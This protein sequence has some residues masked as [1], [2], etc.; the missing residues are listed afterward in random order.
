MTSEEFVKNF[1]TERQ[2]LI[3]IYFDYKGQ[4]D[5]SKMIISLDLDEKKTEIVRNILMATLRDA[6]YTT[7]LGL[8]GEAQIGGRQENYQLTD[9]LGNNLASGQIES[10]A[11]EYFQNNKFNSDNSKA[12]KL[13]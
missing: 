5:V 4:T 10:F 2:R 12:N 11:W 13:S 6:F 9:E 7:L 3:D 8:D 1:H